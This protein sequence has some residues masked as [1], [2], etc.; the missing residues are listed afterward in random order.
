MEV[1]KVCGDENPADLF[2]KHLPSKDKVHSLVRL[3]GCEYRDGR[4]AAAPLLRP[5]EKQPVT[6]ISASTQLP[7][8]CPPEEIDKHFPLFEAAPDDL[9]ATG[10]ND[11]DGQAGN[12]RSVND[13]I[14]RCIDST[15]GI[16]NEKNEPRCVCVCASD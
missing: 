16:V 11:F 5:L 4:S 3:F 12:H 1:R 8:L 7:H 6:S 2:T 15:F 9:F 13:P 14:D 10:G